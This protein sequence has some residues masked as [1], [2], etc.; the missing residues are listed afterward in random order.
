MQF[1]L[2]AELTLDPR[3]RKSMLLLITQVVDGSQTHKRK[4]KDRL[5]MAYIGC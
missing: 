1:I 4:H 3:L 2:D 5:I